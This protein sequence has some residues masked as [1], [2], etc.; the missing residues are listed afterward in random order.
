[1]VMLF[2]R[3][4]TRQDFDLASDGK[5]MIVELDPRQEQPKSS[6]G[7]SSSF[8]VPTHVNLPRNFFEEVRR[9][10]SGGK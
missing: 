6:D 3:H 10:P 2:R 4:D 1:M 8:A 7:R 9:A 5:R